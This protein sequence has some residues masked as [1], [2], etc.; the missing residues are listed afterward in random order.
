MNQSKITTDT[1]FPTTPVD[2]ASHK[3]FSNFKLIPYYPKNDSI[4]CLFSF[5]MLKQAVKDKEERQKQRGPYGNYLSRQILDRIT[6]RYA[7]V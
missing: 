4:F 5:E 3:K 2:S 7:Q 1:Q 6:L